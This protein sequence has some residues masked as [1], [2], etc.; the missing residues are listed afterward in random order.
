MPPLGDVMLPAGRTWGSVSETV[1]NL[2]CFPQLL[3]TPIYVGGTKI[4]P[5]A[6]IGIPPLVPGAS[7]HLT[8]IVASQ[9]RRSGSRALQKWISQARSSAD[10]NIPAGAP[11][12]TSAAGPIIT[13]I[14]SAIIA[15][16]M[17]QPIY[18]L[19]GLIS[20]IAIFPNLL[21]TRHR[22]LKIGTRRD[23]RLLN[24][25]IKEATKTTDLAWGVLTN[26]PQNPSN[27]T[28][29]IN[30]NAALSRIDIAKTYSLK[31]AF[32]LALCLAARGAKVSITGSDANWL[33]WLSQTD[34]HSLPIQINT[35]ATNP[36][37]GRKLQIASE[38]AARQLAALSWQG[39]SLTWGALNGENTAQNTLPE[40]VQ[41]MSLCLRDSA[42]SLREPQNDGGENWAIPLGIG[43]GGVVNFD[44]VKDGPHLLIAG[45]TG[46][47]KSELLRSLV[48]GIA[49]DKSPAELNLVLIDFKGGASFGNCAQLPHVVGMVTDLDENLAQ[50]AISGLR[51]E[52]RRRKLLLAEY[53]VSDIAALPPGTLPRLMVVLDEFRALTEELPDA[54]DQLLRV[55]AQGRSLGV[56]LVLATQRASGAISAEVRANVS[57]RLALRVVDAADSVDLLEAPT[58]AD[59]PF[60]AGRA[61][62]KLGSLPEVVFQSAYADAVPAPDVYRPNPSVEPARAKPLIPSVEEPRK[63]RLETM[64]PSVEPVETTGD[65]RPSARIIAQISTRYQGICPGNPPWLPPLPKRLTNAELYRFV[66]TLRDPTLPVASRR[67]YAAPQ[68][69]GPQ[70]DERAAGSA[71]DDG[72]LVFGATS[73]DGKGNGGGEIWIGLGDFPA[74]QAQAAVGWSPESGTLGI[75][76]GARSGRTTALLTVSV[77][78]V[79]K[80]WQVH[81]LGELPASA[82]TLFK[83]PNFGTAVPISDIARAG[84]LL[85]HL[86]SNSSKTIL[87]IDQIERWRS[88][89]QDHGVDPLGTLPPSLP[90]AL[91][92]N[93]ATCGGLASH[94]TAKLLLLSA[95]RNDDLIV[96]APAN[97]AGLGRSPGRGVWLTGPEQTLTQVAL[98]NLDF[99]T[100]PIQVT[101]LRIREIPSYVEMSELPPGAL[102]IG[103][104]DAAPQ[105]LDLAGGALVV[106]PRGSGRTTALQALTA[107]FKAQFN[108]ESIYEI[109]NKATL[110]TFAEMIENPPQLLVID[111]ID[112][113][114]NL[115]GP[116]LERLSELMQNGDIT[117]L[118]TTTTFHATITTRGIVGQL[119]A[120]RTGIVLHPAERGS[121]EVF[122]AELPPPHDHPIPGRGWQVQKGHPTPIQLC[123]YT[124][125]MMRK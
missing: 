73:R 65:T 89:F 22:R 94:L 78:A 103:S 64:A 104:D 50:R 95:D 105:F 77:E 38:R 26:R 14:G 32:R 88:R 43:V 20:L 122:A 34:E 31:K 1:A 5:G 12:L 109:S 112:V 116:Q 55:A 76:G 56:H 69:T 93:N 81:L 27:E 18:A 90:L 53:N 124:E 57:A 83:H 86:N 60:V 10:P 17:G 99:P 29:D 120:K 102:G 33:H 125:G 98:P 41:L 82:K 24:N 2:L 123:N 117:V 37:R 59:L 6:V 114:A 11:R 100:T 96:G 91:T 36:A 67:R 66:P 48:L 113:L 75:I 51:A 118:A 85:N 9:P 62:L 119:R 40:L 72:G 108:Y 15:Y 16:T 101:A 111:D 106:G 74:V 63:R 92:S 4:P 68:P 23:Y 121:G 84:R 107:S 58:A 46:S 3:S 97:F 45:T 8:K 47:G 21:G 52:L 49:Y 42:I 80:G 35:A 70:D 19:F 79:Q 87:L 7:L 110:A 28:T 30:L 54:I 25:V 44:L 13:G 71:P 115:F 39:R 61:V